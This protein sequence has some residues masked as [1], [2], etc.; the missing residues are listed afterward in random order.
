VAEAEEAE[1]AEEVVV[2]TI[3]HATVVIK[4]P[5]LTKSL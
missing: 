3:S 5:V 1:E 4:R 2:V